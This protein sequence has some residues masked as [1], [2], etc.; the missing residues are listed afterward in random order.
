VKTLV[1]E[2][3]PRPLSLTGLCP[4]I[5]FARGAA[6]LASLGPDGVMNL[7]VRVGHGPTAM[8]GFRETTGLVTLYYTGWDAFVRANNTRTDLVLFDD[9]ND[10]RAFLTNN[11]KVLL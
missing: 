7:L 9:R 8:Y 3:T 1:P 10:L 2:T 11:P 4:D 6:V 5:L